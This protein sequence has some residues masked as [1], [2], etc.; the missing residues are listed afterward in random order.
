MPANFPCPN[1]V[2]TE[3][4][5]AEAVKGASRLKCPRCGTQFEFRRPAA[6]APAKPRTAIPK[7]EAPKPPSGSIQA[8]A[9]QAAAPG[10]RRSGLARPATAVPPAAPVIP[11]AAPVASESADQS[12]LDFDSGSE[13]VHRAPRRRA[14]MPGWLTAALL[15]LLLFGGAALLVVGAVRMSMNWSG[16]SGLSA[17]Q[18]EAFIKQANFS[19]VPPA[20]PW[21]QDTGL[22]AA[23]KVDLAYRRSGPSSVMALSFKDYKKRLPRDAELI[24]GALGKLRS[25]LGNVEYEAQPK[26]DEIKLAGQP[27]IQLDFTGEDPEHVP[28]AGQC[29]TTA[30][31]GIGYWFY[32]WGPVE[33][34]E[35]LAI[36]WTA[37]RDNFKLG[38]QR[39]GWTEAPRELLS[40]KGVKLPYRL[41]Y[42]KGLWE[43][44]PLDGYDKR[45]DVVLLG[46]DPKDKEA[47]R[48]EMAGLVQVLAL[49]AAADLET[50]SKEARDYLLEMEKEKQDGTGE[51]YNFPEATVDVVNE[52]SLQNTDV[53]T[54]L[55]GFRGH[56]YKLEV[57]KSAD[58]RKYV[59]M[60]VVNMEGDGV[61]AA[62]CECDWARRDYW[63]Q[64]F[65]PLLDRLKSTK[66]K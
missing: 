61:L 40:V 21:Q 62:V 9:P 25:Y 51:K 12:S 36:E 6:A 59:V 22:Q 16:S 28:V 17:E 49:P 33:D 4:F 15:L 7:A 3:V 2:C 53:V 18:A 37:F 11:M 64:E 14:G 1:P 10:L 46:Y 8:A 54:N 63:D 5:D 65:T 44:Q 48:G 24:D 43:K 66:P 42:T 60:A 23:M 56:L 27:A 34:Q 57:K 31:R 58:A 39:E 50:A 41:D 38:D 20:R 26:S 29:L 47:R 30:S 52:K 35:K 45:A 55:G 32:T 13:V 19:I